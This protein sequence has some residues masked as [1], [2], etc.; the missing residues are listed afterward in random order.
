MKV[1]NMTAVAT[2]HGLTCGYGST[3]DG[4]QSLIYDAADP[5]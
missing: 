1:E 2:I 4:I 5:F 3:A